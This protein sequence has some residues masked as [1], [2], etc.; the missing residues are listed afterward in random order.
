MKGLNMSI[1][2]AFSLTIFLWASAFP[3]IKLAL[4]DFDAI[5]LSTL[6]LIIA[7]LVL[8]FIGLIKKISLPNIK[9]MPFILLLGFLGFTVYHTALSIGEDYVSSGIASLIVSTTPIFSTLL[10]TLFFK[11]AFSK[12]A[13]IG[14]LIALSGVALISLGN[15]GQL[16]F[17]ITGILLVLL[18]S[19]GEST[20]FS[21]QHHY[22]KKYGFFPLTLYTIVAGSLFMLLFLPDSILEL[23]SASAMSLISVLYLGLFPTVIPYIALAYTIQKVGVSDATISLY[24]TPAV[25]LILSYF[26]LREIPTFISL[27]GGVII[28]IGVTLTTIH[29]NNNN[30]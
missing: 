14:S 19:I 24:L 5:H 10:A 25:S 3:V 13:W 30:K 22:L 2:V 23:Q 16:Q 29:S 21:F 8:I 12:I 4:K 1:V 15:D 20:Y 28:L 11:E 6:R 7:A 17:G 18:A 27:V 9:D 26:L